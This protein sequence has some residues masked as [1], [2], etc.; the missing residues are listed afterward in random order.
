MPKNSSRSKKIPKFIK[1]L[2]QILEVTAIFTQNSKY[3][4]LISWQPDG[5]SFKILDTSKFI[6]QVLP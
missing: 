5:D 1:K 4:H 3:T 6:D 2:N